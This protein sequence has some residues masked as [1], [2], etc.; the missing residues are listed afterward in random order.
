MNSQY[1]GGGYSYTP[2]RTSEISQRSSSGVPD[3][4]SRILESGPWNF[5]PRPYGQGSRGGEGVRYGNVGMRG[6]PHSYQP[7]HYGTGNRM[8]TSTPEGLM[9]HDYVSPSD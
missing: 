7:Q 2:V 8:A 5:T 1:R 3:S 6:E 9:S 4:R